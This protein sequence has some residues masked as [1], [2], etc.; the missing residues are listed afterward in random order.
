MVV[1]AE[2]ATKTL[3]LGSLL[4]TSERPIAAR[5]CVALYILTWK[6]ASRHNSVH[7]FASQLLKVLRSC[8][9]LYILTWKCA[10]HHNG[11]QFFISHLAT[12]LRTLSTL[13]SHKSL[14][15]HSVSRL[16]TFLPFRAPASSFFSLFLFSDLLSS[17]LLFSASLP[18]YRGGRG[19]TKPT[20]RIPLFFAWKPWDS[21]PTS[22][23]EF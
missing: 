15:K 7:F 4:M 19:G 11:V 18:L 13:R 8:S 5:T 1:V 2:T 22:Q 3:T 12:W 21:D 14:E 10:S 16:A 9:A 20:C 17:A 23:M 6:C